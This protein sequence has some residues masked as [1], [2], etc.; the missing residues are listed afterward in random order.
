MR[1]SVA[2]IDF[3][4]GPALVVDWLQ[5]TQPARLGVSPVIIL[6]RECGMLEWP[7]R[8]LGSTGVLK[9]PIRSIELIQLC[10]SL[11]DKVPHQ[12]RE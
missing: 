6:P 9:A 4:A 10:R 2:V 3:E 5:H 12:S 1:G 7:L 8:E 11:L